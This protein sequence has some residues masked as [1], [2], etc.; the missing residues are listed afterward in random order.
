[1]TRR[2]AHFRLM[3]ILIRQVGHILGIDIGWITDNQ[4]KAL[5][6]QAVKAV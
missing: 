6:G 3:Q 5:A 4:I 1:M 2:Q